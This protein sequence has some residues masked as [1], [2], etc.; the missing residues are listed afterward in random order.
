MV[1]D[2]RVEPQYV[3]SDRFP[4]RE[5]VYAEIAAQ[6]AIARAAQPALL[7]LPYGAHP[8]ERIDLFPGQD[9]APLLVFIHGGYWRSQQKDDYAFVANALRR[10]G[11]SVAVAGYPLAPER[12]LPGIV[13]SLRSALA[14]LH[15]AGSVLLPAWRETVI[16]GH[17]AGGHLAAM[18]A[19]DAEFGPTIAGCLALSGLYDL[20]PLSRTSIGIQVGIDSA[21]AARL[22]PLML[23]V[24]PG[25]FIAAVGGNET[26][27]FLEQAS[28]YAAHWSASAAASDLVVVAGA[29][30]YSILRQMAEL[31][32]PVLRLLMARTGAR[33]GIR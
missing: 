17:S 6:S 21:L 20:A 9:G 5:A 1:I 30:H 26:A 2:P 23:P 8:R 15:G 19:S 29:D 12:S 18:L 33:E 25:W 4:S 3:F 22:S 32:G 27:A 28:R 14:W 16:A 31:D 13:Q 7:D 10:R 11:F 24:G